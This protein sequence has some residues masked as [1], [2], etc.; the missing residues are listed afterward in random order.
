MAGVRK[1]NNL[2]GTTILTFFDKMELPRPDIDV[3]WDSRTTF[4]K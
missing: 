3:I 2:H 4:T 1:Y